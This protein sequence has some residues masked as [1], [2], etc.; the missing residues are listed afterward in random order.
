MPSIP[1]TPRASKG[2]ME[3][4]AFYNPLQLPKAMGPPLEEEL[5]PGAMPTWVWGARKG[6]AVRVCVA[7]TEQAALGAALLSKLASE[8]LLGLC[9]CLLLHP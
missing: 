1:C 5:P 4:G 9:R 6:R 2:E 7:G 8:H 3:S